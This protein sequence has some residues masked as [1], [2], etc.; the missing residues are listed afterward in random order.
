VEGSVSPFSDRLDR[1]RSAIWARRLSFPSQT[2]VFARQNCPDI[3]WRLA[4]LYFIRGWS[5]EQ[6]AGR[7]GVTRSRIRQ[8]IRGWVKQAAMRGYLQPIPG[9][10]QTV[11]AAAVHT[12]VTTA[13]SH[14]A[15][16]GIQDTVNWSHNNL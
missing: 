13:N 4:A 8:S 16:A 6:L 10:T 9:E 11:M 15:L 5:I 2:P 7:Y 12:A 3:Q 1:I 14:Y